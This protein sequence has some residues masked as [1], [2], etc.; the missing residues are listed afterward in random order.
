VIYRS[1][2]KLIM[3]MISYDLYAFLYRYFIKYPCACY[4]FGTIER[5]KLP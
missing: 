4:I 5:F 2:N 1:G 3:M